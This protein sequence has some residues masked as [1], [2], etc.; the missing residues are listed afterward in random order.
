MVYDEES[1]H[2]RVGDHEGETHEGEFERNET[3]INM[4]AC[5]SSFL[6]LGCENRGRMI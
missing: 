5:D 1:T 6:S 2:G 4:S 3:V